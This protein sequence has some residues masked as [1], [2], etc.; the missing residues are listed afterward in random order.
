MCSALKTKLSGVY[1]VLL[2]VLSGMPGFSPFTLT[3]R[4]SPAY[5]FFRANRSVASFFQITV[6][7]PKN[8]RK[9]KSIISWL[10][11]KIL[12]SGKSSSSSLMMRAR[13]CSC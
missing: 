6:S 9:P 10:V 3:T 4:I 2:M 11:V 13:L 7:V 12:D 5:T 8:R 1:L